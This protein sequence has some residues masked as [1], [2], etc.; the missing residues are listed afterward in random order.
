MGGIYN[1]A[2]RTASPTLAS[3]QMGTG[4]VA[5]LPEQGARHADVG[6]EVQDERGRGELTR[7]EEGF[8]LDN[9]A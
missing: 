3:R 6:I 4:R 2:L 7:W 1:L 5:K 9:W 8:Q